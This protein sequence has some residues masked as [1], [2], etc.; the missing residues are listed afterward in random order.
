MPYKTREQQTE[1]Q[2]R[3]QQAR[4]AAWIEQHGPCAKC[5]SDEDLEVDHIDESKKRFKAT[6]LWSRAM[7]DP[8][9]V[10]E[11][12]ELSGALFEVS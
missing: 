4:R 10:A 5:G 6:H 9:V 12:S 7:T 8:K 1:Y 11:L 2:K 3:W